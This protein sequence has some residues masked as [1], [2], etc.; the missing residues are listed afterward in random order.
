MDVDRLWNK[1][2][3]NNTKCLGKQQIK[4]FVDTLVLFADEQT[5]VNYDPNNFDNLFEQCDQ[6]QDGFLRKSE[7][8]LFLKKGFSCQYQNQ[9]LNEI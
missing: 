2:D 3:T 8:A 7:I 6:S 5:T 9:E 4:N 1:A